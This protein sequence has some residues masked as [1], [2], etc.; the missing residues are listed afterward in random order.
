V[1][2]APTRAALDAGTYDEAWEV[3]GGHLN[4]VT[5][6]RM[7]RVREVAAEMEPYWQRTVYE[8]NPELAFHH[9]ND[10]ATLRFPKTSSVGLKERRE[11]LE[12]KFQGVARILETHVKGARERHIVDAVA[13]LWIARRIAS[14][15]ALRLPEKPEWD[16][17]GL[18]MEIVY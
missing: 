13:S 15:S 12:N 5:W 10:G 1:P 16:D 17:Q 6:A 18:R 9:L 3:S 11:L 2:T 4:P 14:K 7:P 8:V